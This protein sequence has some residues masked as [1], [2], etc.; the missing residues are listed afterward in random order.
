MSSPFELDF[1]PEDVEA[2]RQGHVTE[3][4]QAKLT[5]LARQQRQSVGWGIVAFAVLIAG[6]IGFEFVR[7][8]GTLERFARGQS[9]LV[10][11]GL[12]FFFAVLVLMTIITMIA[13]RALKHPVVR[14][15]EGKVKIDT[16]SAKQ[17][18]G[19]VY[20]VHLVKIGK[21]TFRFLD[22]HSLSFFRDGAAYRAYLIKAP[23]QPS[24]IPLSVEK[25]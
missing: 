14:R 22:A 17:G 11:W 24:P 3:S 10:V 13:S 20:T 15:I 23:L 4:Q 25:V 7:T 2:N 5:A 12:A 1:T 19:A 21:T 6:G 8:G 9:P 16:F 18:R